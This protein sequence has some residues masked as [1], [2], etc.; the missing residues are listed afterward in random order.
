MLSEIFM[1]ENY[2]CFSETFFML[3]LLCN[4]TKKLRLL[5]NLFAFGAFSHLEN[6]LRC[7]LRIVGEKTCKKRMSQDDGLELMIDYYDRKN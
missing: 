3:R 7:K 5:C 2:N 1:E 4:Y 6:K